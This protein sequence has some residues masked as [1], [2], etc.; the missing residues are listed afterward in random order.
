MHLWQDSTADVVDYRHFARLGY[1]YAIG[2]QG[3]T[4]MQITPELSVGIGPRFTWQIKVPYV[5]ASGNLGK[6]SGVGDII[7]T[8]SY[9]F[10]NEDEHH[11][12]AMVGVRLPTG[13]TSQDPIE[14]TSFGSDFR[15]LP[16]PYQTGLGTTDLLAGV[17]WR[18]HRYVAALAYQHVLKQDNQNLFLHS[19]W[20]NDPDALGYFESFMLERADDAVLR[21]QYAYG[22]KR[23]AL[24]PGLLAIYHMSTDS[25]LEQ[26]GEPIDW[27]LYELERR[28]VEGSEG[29]TLNLTADLRYALS[30]RW[31]I[32]TTFGTP[33]L[34]RD[35]RP[36]GLTRSLVV[37]AWLRFRF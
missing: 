33:L 29:L 22:C 14:K 8:A 26:V 2:E 11:L 13:T 19:F 30:E 15:P 23:L 32:E 28:E 7:T 3:T 1:S 9:A 17:E 16:M 25:R 34:T 20:G 36:D 5:T 24:Q 35:V 4:I 12:S 27:N 21:L 10:I 31:A 37:G 18:Y 6:N